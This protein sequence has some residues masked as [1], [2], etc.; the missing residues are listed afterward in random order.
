MP[1]PL[2]SFDGH[3]WARKKHLF[4]IGIGRGG[5]LQRYRLRFCPSHVLDVEE[6][7]AQYEVASEYVALGTGD[8]HWRR[9]LPCGKP[10]DELSR[11]LFITGYPAKDERKDYWAQV[12]IG[13]RLP[14]FLQDSYTNPENPS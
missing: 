8:S 9:C 5:D 6:Y 3:F 1:L 10:A 12:H 7:L 2:C 4:Y 11:Q 13:C 14:D